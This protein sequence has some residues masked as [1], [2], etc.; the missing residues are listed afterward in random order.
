M[1]TIFCKLVLPLFYFHKFTTGFPTTKL[2]IIIDDKNRVQQI[3]CVRSILFNLFKAKNIVY[4]S[5]EHA[6]IQTFYN[7]QF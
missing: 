3:F 7:F 5:F 1:F 4:P 2:S 6:D